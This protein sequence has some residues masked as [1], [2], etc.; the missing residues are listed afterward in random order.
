MVDD[1]GRVE[2]GGEP[3]VAA[4]M[5]R[6]GEKFAGRY[7]VQRMIG[8]GGMGEVYLAT[9]TPLGREVALKIL[10]PPENIEDDPN[11]EDRFLNEAAAAA[12]LQHPNTIT[13]YDFGQTDDGILYICMEYL[14]GSDLRTVIRHEGIFTAQRAVHVAKQ[15]CKSLREAH[16]KGM[17]HRDL[18]PANVLLIERDDDV[19]F[20]KV[21]D[22]GLVKFQGDD[23]ITLAGRFLGSPKYSSPEAFDRNRV[24]DHRADIYAMGILIYTMVTGTTPFDGD[25]IQ[26]LN[27]HLNEPPKPMWKMNSAAKT[28]E[29][30]EGI[31]Q[32]C[33][34]KQPRD[35]FQ[36]MAELLQALRAVG[37]Q[38]GDEETATLE[39]DEASLFDTD[40][41]KIAPVRQTEP[42]AAAAPDVRDPS[43][44]E[45][46]ATPQKKSALP[47]ILGLVAV[48]AVAAFALRPG[49]TPEPTAPGEASP[50]ATPTAKPNQ[51][52]LKARST[53]T[54]ARISYR[55]PKGEWVALG[56]TPLDKE[57]RPEAGVQRLTFRIEAEGHVT[58]ELER[59][60]DSGAVELN[61][62]LNPMP[63]ATPKPTPTTK[64]KPKPTPKPKPKA[65]PKPKPKPKPTPQ[66]TPK[67]TPKPAGY[68]DN[69]YL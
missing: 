34:A 5:P 41:K 19:D 64:P 56:T 27:A 31:V 7:V 21:L 18:K 10:K 47:L 45:A 51:A 4:Q 60:V 13:V 14:R 46:A 44:V 33:L 40:T 29:D 38:W 54:G 17:I 50:A 66:P 25:P 15:V 39:L 62:Q 52:M 48:A 22:F 43:G 9:Q 69:P 28:T 63:A 26:I 35:R 53:P 37:A 23:E 20:V 30:L 16:N 61:V 65:T 6:P 12:R 2:R 49:P 32:K 42:V 55:N 36:D 11:F 68:K 58:Q 8:K 57:L 59:G 3:G 1:G 24:L 67:P